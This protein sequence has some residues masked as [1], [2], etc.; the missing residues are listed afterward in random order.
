MALPSDILRQKL[1]RAGAAAVGF[2]ALRE[3]APR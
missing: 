3:V 2:A 1:L